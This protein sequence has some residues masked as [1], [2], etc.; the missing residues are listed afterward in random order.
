VPPTWK[1][2][3]PPKKSMKRT[4]STQSGLSFCSTVESFEAADVAIGTCMRFG[5]ATPTSSLESPR[6]LADVESDV[7]S[8][9][10]DTTNVD[11][12]NNM[13]DSTSTSLSGIRTRLK[14]EAPAFQPMPTDTRFDVVASAVYLAL[15]S[16]GKTHN[17]KIEKGL[18]GKSSTWISAE[19]RCGDCSTA[20]CYDAVHLAR[21]ALEEVTGR[22]DTV[23]LL[24]KR[25]EKS[26]GGYSLRSSIACIPKGAEDTTC[27]DLFHKGK[28]PRR[29]KCPWYH[30]Q[31]ADIGRVK[32]SITCTEE[33]M[34]VSSQQEQLPASF[35]VVRHKISLGELV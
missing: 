17:T 18:Q 11:D 35:P 9:M 13:N 29:G 15:A 30:P 24:S 3:T 25:V 22:L 26:D 4:L 6:D 28:C 12:D 23:A 31:E 16:C 10:D 7:V 5:H 27:W 34:G 8:N 21:Q 33:V 1:P 32:V 2:V 14:G 20:R 19:L